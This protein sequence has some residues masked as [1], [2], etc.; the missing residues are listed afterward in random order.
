MVAPS[1]CARRPVA[2]SGSCCA[3]PTRWSRRRTGESAGPGALGVAA[4]RSL[5][6]VEGSLEQPTRYEACAA[7]AGRRGGDCEGSLEQP[8]R[9]EAC[10]ATAGR[11]GGDREGSLEQPT[12]YEA[13]AATAGRRCTVLGADREGRDADSDQHSHHHTRDS[14]DRRVPTSRICHEAH[15]TP[16]LV[17]STA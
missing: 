1:S 3:S 14:D 7:T 5:L 6:A 17:W 9:Y 12:R 15:A 13:C 2:A 16:L 4:G 11:R 8:T 10:A